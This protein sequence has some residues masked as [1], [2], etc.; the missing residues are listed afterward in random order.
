ME[1]HSENPNINLQE[2]LDLC[3]KHAHDTDDETIDLHA[4]IGRVLAENVVA[5]RDMPPFNKAAVDGYAC[6]K[7]D[8]P[9]SLRPVATIAAGDD[10]DVRLSP[11]ECV[12]IMTGASVP[13]GADW[14]VM[15]EHTRQNDDGLI[16]ITG[17]GRK[18]N[19]ALKAE[20]YASGDVLIRKGQ[21]L[22]SQHIALMAAEGYASPKVYSKP[23]VQIVTTGDELV[24]PHEFPGNGQ[25]RN[26]NAIQLQAQLN[27]IGIMADYPGIVPDDKAALRQVIKRCDAYDISFFTGGISMGD[28]DYVPGLIKEAG[29][30]MI[31][32]KIAVK[33]G[34]PTVLA[35]K[36]KH[37][38]M[39]LP[40]NPVSGFI[41]FLLLG[42]P[43]IYKMMNADYLPEEHF[44]PLGEDL[45]SKKSD[46]D[47]WI[48]VQI[49]KNK[50]YPVPYNGSGDLAA[51]RYAHGFICIPAAVTLLKTKDYVHVRPV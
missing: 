22:K 16:D 32:Q 47:S 42:K 6:R 41:Q 20:D 7:S 37:L 48:P 24:E 19:I 8:M 45:P 12:K 31:F 46:R 3:L 34:K 50:V 10:A 29:Y 30:K 28:Y 5:V 36:G 4:A 38:I 23:R 25:I 27:Q 11:G 9:G 17:T 49:K 1:T 39:G 35:K 33:P 15:V 43:L 13:D 51:L 21:I 26:S 2:A 40:G 44:L 14:V 18:S